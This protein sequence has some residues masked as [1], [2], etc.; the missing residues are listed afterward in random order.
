MIIEDY[1]TIIDDFL[2]ELGGDV[3][4]RLNCQL[5]LQIEALD[6]AS[7]GRDVFDR[8]Q[9]M[10]PFTLKC[11][12]AMRLAAHQD[13]IESQLV[14]AFRSVEYQ[15][16]LIRKKVAAGQQLD[17]IFK[18]SAIPGFSEHHTGRALDLSTPG[19][20]PL[21]EAFDQTAAFEW[22]NTHAHRFEFSMSYPRNNTTG[23]NYE[24]WHWACRAQ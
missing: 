15:C 24:P 11:W 18:I 5:P 20:E 8:E 21:S 23:I 13:D 7:A 22:L 12:Q 10:T 4:L 17:D 14:S 2:R 16:G 19:P 9:W 1:T 3:N 6:L